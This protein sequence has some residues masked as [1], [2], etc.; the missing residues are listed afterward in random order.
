LFCL[1][2]IKLQHIVKSLA[3][4]PINAAQTIVAFSLMLLKELHK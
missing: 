4:V 3:K 1:G 2:D